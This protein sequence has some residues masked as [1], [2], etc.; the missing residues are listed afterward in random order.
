MNRRSFEQLNSGCR[1]VTAR[2]FHQRRLRRAHSLPA[3]FGLCAAL[4][5][6]WWEAARDGRPSINALQC[7]SPAFVRDLVE[8]QCRSAWLLEEVPTRGCESIA[9][10][11]AVNLERSFDATIV[12]SRLWKDCVAA[13]PA[14]ALVMGESGLRL[15]SLRYGNTGHR[16]AL[17]VEAAGMLRFFDPNAGEAYFSCAEYFAEWLARFWPAAGYARRSPDVTV[18]HFMPAAP[19]TISSHGS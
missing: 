18:F 13:P 12:E 5:E 9:N 6:V 10:P 11:L 15:L 2:H 17:S 16:M 7:E 4:V 3:G 14:G 1:V 8:R 19:A